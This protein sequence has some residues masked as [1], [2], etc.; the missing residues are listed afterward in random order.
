VGVRDLESTF[1]NAIG[2][3]LFDL[4]VHNPAASSTS[5]AAAF[6]TRNYTIAPGSAWSER[7]EVEGFAAP[8]WVDPSGTGL[9]TVRVVPIKNPD[10]SGTLTLLM[11]RAAFGNPT[12]GWS[13]VLT[14]TGQDGFSGDR[15]R[16]FTATPGAFTFGVCA[17]V[18]TDPHCTVDPSTV[19]KVIDT[20]T[21]PGV[22]QSTELDYTLGPV[23]LQGV[24]IP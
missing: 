24:P 17:T 1:G 12:S 9:G 5:T 4:Y 6:A 3:Q 20:V 2:A 23:T 18:S 13:F 16:G 19:P 10:N 15:A 21:P 7:I 14:L 8:V 11:P 22:L